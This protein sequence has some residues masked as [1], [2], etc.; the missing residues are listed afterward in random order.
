MARPDRPVRLQVLL[1]RYLPEY[2]EVE[3]CELRLYGVLRSSLLRTEHAERLPTVM[4]L[5]PH[6]AG[7]GPERSDGCAPTP[8]VVHAG[9]ADHREG[10]QGDRHGLVLDPPYAPRRA[11]AVPYDTLCHGAHTSSSPRSMVRSLS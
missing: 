1:K 4:D 11:A 10:D 8:A 3:F 7:Q 5:G 6:S 9:P 2:L